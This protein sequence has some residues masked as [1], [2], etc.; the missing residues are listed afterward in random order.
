[1]ANRCF[2]TRQV[3]SSAPCSSA[4]SSS[5]S[6]AAFRCNLLGLFLSG[7]AH[8]FQRLLRDS[9][10]LACDCD[11]GSVCVCRGVWVFVSLC[12]GVCALLK[13]C[14]EAANVTDVTQLIA[15]AASPNCSYTNIIH[16]PQT[17]PYSSSQRQS[18]EFLMSRCS[19]SSRCRP[20]GRRQGQRQRQRETW[21]DL[22]WCD[23]TR[24]D[25]DKLQSARKHWHL[26]HSLTQPRPRPTLH[27]PHSG[28]KRARMLNIEPQSDWHQMNSP[29]SLI[30]FS[31]KLSLSLP[32]QLYRVY[33]KSSICH[34]MANQF[35]RPA[36]LPGCLP[37]KNHMNFALCLVRSFDDA[38]VGP[39]KGKMIRKRG[40]FYEL[41]N[42]IN[43]YINLMAAFMKIE[44]HNN[45]NN[46]NNN[47]IA[48]RRRGRGIK[49]HKAA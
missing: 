8:L 4:S 40:N 29:S 23:L 18:H 17:H 37:V 46:S 30:G 20:H 33:S 16:P 26:L 2:W 14:Q 6:S 13:S 34:N 49:E 25:F 12:A 44:Y 19:S 31:F 3:V 28:P 10:Y 43:F 48:A 38:K 15:A 36:C 35:R 7:W 47:D 41:W 22:T 39:K 9:H 42:Q 21:L 5:S 24:L 1:M 45:V 27:L 32:V 11:C